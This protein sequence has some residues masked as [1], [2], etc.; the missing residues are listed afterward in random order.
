[1]LFP[2]LSSVRGSGCI[3]SAPAKGGRGFHLLITLAVFPC[4]ELVVSEMVNQNTHQPARGGTLMSTALM[5]PALV[6][7]LMLVGTKSTV[8]MDQYRTVSLHDSSE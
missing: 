8:T 1:M 6:N 3:S 7:R 5:N 4:I 2:L